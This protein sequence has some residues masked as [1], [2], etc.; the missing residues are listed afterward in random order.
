MERAGL[1]VQEAHLQ[2]MWLL[3]VEALV[4]TLV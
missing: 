3:V 4:D 2:V 1:V